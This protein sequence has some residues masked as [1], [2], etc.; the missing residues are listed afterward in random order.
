MDAVT[1]VEDTTALAAYVQGLV[2][3][4]SDAYEAGRELPATTGS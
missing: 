2:K 1:R 4:Y 3:Y